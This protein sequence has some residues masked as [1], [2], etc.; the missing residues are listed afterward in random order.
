MLFLKLLVDHF[1]GGIIFSPGGVSGGGGPNIDLNAT[2]MSSA[3][4]GKVNSITTT[5]LIQKTGMISKQCIPISMNM[6]ISPIH[7]GVVLGKVNIAITL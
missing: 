6:E 1:C 7:H 2:L 4:T 3:D 5:G